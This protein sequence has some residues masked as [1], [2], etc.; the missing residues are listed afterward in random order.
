MCKCSVLNLFYLRAVCCNVAGG[1][2]SDKKKAPPDPY[3]NRGNTPFFLQ[4]ASD[5]MCLGE[6]DHRVLR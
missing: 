1:G 3:D 5:E 6:C 2:Q 4:D